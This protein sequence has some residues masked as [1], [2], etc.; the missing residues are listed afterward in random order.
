MRLFIVS[1]FLLSCSYSPAVLAEP[2]LSEKP[3]CSIMHNDS[4]RTV[5]IAVRTNYFIAPN[6]E[7]NRHE[8][9]LRLEPMQKQQVCAQGPFYDD[10]RVE[11]IL[12]TIIPLFDCKTKLGDDLR[13]TQTKQKDNVVTLSMNCS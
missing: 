10:Y 12:R 8:A 2:L 6:G 11:I 3:L 13:I 4:E 9:S 1:L 5:F 7:K